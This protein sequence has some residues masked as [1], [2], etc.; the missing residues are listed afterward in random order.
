MTYQPIAVGEARVFVKLDNVRPATAAPYQTMKPLLQ[1][2]LERK[3]REQ[4]TAQLL[5]KLADRAD[6]VE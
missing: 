1:R 2:E 3:V 4:A 5:R 6:I